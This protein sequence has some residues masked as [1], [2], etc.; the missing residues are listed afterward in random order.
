VRSDGHLHSYAGRA[1]VPSLLPP[2]FPLS[3]LN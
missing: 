1:Y 2:G 3:D